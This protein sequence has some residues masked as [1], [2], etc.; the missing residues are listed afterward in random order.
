M[1]EKE[2]KLQFAKLLFK[3]PLGAHDAA[4]ELFF[5]D[6]GL[7]LKV[8]NEW[9]KDQIVKNEI[10]RLRI[11]EPEL[12]EDQIIKNELCDELVKIAKNKNTFASDRIK[13]IHAWA[14]LKGQISERELRQSEGI[15]HRVMKFKSLGDNWENEIQLQQSKLIQDGTKLIN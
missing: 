7:M 6:T 1:N 15:V 2:L 5:H 10:E 12:S 9:P 14:L 4:A 3:K 8:A 11:D 13:A